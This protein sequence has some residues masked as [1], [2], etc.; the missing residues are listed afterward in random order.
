MKG[1]L[2]QLLLDHAAPLLFVAAKQ[3]KTI[4]AETTLKKGRSIN[5]LI[6]FSMSISSSHFLRFSGQQ[7]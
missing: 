1:A 5:T 2:Q 3:S 6:S 7:D 4:A